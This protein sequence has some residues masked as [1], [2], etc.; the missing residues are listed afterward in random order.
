MA[1]LN[2]S[3]LNWRRVVIDTPGIGIG[4]KAVGMYL[5][6][7]MNEDHHMAWPSLDRMQYELEV[8]RNSIVKYL[9]AL[10]DAGL[11]YRQRRF[12]Q[13]TV[14]H[15]RFPDEIEKI[16]KISSSAN[17]ILVEQ[18]HP[19]SP[20][21]S[22]IVKEDRSST[23]I[24]PAQKDNR[25]PFDAFWAVYPRRVGKKPTQP[26]WDHLKP[27]E[28]EAVLQDCRTRQWSSDKN[29]IPHPQT[30]LRQRRWEDEEAQS[31]P[32]FGVDL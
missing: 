12:G 4:A 24:K 22:L 2:L 25:I 21:G 31:G 7:F 28:Q 23:P 3:W 11:L 10:E 9:K 20:V 18:M 6:T 29:F 27:Q 1:E 30:Y 16:G 17:F 13:N 15:A 8:S 5:S 26:L 32:R 19:N 14:Y